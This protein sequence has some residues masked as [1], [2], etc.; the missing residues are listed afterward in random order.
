MTQEIPSM[1]NC[2]VSVTNPPSLGIVAREDPLQKVYNREENL[3]E[4]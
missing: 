1:L 4:I 2:T 3:L